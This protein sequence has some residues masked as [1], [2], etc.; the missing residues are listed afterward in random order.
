MY[1]AGTN[2][3]MSPQVE[4]EAEKWNARP[5]RKLRAQSASDASSGRQALLPGAFHP[6][7][8]QRTKSPVS[9]GAKA[10]RAQLVGR[11]GHQPSI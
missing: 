1:A 7:G 8:L 10:K 3:S 11:S 2:M 5:M 9:E 6:R 4:V